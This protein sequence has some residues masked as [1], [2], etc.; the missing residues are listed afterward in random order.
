MRNQGNREGLDYGRSSGTIGQVNASTCFF[1]LIFFNDCQRARFRKT[2]AKTSRR[3]RE[4]IRVRELAATHRLRQM[5]CLLMIEEHKIWKRE[6]GFDRVE[7]A[8]EMDENRSCTSTSPVPD[9]FF[10]SNML[11]L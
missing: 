11:N 6:F 9:P 4:T 8:A 10:Y 7:T 2:D 1:Y 3:I 5:R